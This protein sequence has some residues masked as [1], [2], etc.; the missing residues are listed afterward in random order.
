MIGRTIGG[1]RIVEQVGMGG[2]ATVYKAY[3]AS[4]DRYVALKTLPE[5]YSKDP[6]FVER[7]RREA[8]AIAKLEHL[9]ILPLFAYGED[10][11]TAYLAMRYL[12]AG[13]LSNYIREQG[14]IP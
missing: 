9:H 10:Q 13:T 3:D 7:F 14:Q 6:Q 4:T 11:G 5:Q 12:P 8:R 2:M 1:Y